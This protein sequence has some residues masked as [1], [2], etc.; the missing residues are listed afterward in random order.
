MKTQSSSS[1]PA[2]SSAA[3]TH[4]ERRRRPREAAP[5]PI[6]PVEPV[7]GECLGPFFARASAPSGVRSGLQAPLPLRAIPNC[8]AASTLRRAVAVAA[9]LSGAS[10]E[11]PPRAHVV[12]QIVRLRVPG[13]RLE[14]AHQLLA[15]VRALGLAQLLHALAAVHGHLPALHI[16]I[17]FIV[18]FFERGLSVWFR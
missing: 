9:A 4:E 13:V 3:P 8:I 6:G 12:L 15:H 11:P 7:A 10:I 16:L 17:D 5:R 2:A 14:T 18:S 1:A